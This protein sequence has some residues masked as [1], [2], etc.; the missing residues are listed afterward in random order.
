MGEER[1]S[2][3][4]TLPSTSRMPEVVAIRGSSQYTGHGRDV[5]TKEPTAN[6]GEATNGVDVVEG[7]HAAKQRN[8]LVGK[9]RDLVRVLKLGQSVAL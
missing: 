9:T 3:N 8:G 1:P 2:Y 7:L 5:E 6:G 4:T